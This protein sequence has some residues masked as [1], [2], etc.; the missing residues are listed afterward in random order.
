MGRSRLVRIPDQPSTDADAI[1]FADPSYA[2]RLA[3]SV[4]C[5]DSLDFGW[6]RNSPFVI[7]NAVIHDRINHP[8]DRFASLPIF[9]T[10]S[11]LLL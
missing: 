10:V 11:S 6:K 2:V 8:P 4:P 7:A 5:H 1:Y 3:D 9:L